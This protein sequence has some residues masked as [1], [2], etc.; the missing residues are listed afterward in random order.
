M[1]QPTQSKQRRTIGFACSEAGTAA[2]E[3]AIV[4]GVI[5]LAIVS[6]VFY[7]GKAISDTAGALTA[8]LDSSSAREVV[9][10]LPQPAIAIQEPI[11]FQLFTT[12]F[13][14]ASAFLALGLLWRNRR[15]GT[16]I[17]SE[18]RDDFDETEVRS[19]RVRIS[20]TLKSHRA[21]FSEWSLN[22]EHV[23]LTPTSLL[24]EDKRKQKAQVTPTTA[25]N[26]RTFHVFDKADAAVGTLTQQDLDIAGVHLARVPDRLVAIDSKTAVSTAIVFMQKNS[27][28]VLP[29]ISNGSIVGLVTRDVLMT[30]LH[31][32]LQ[33]ISEIDADYRQVLRRAVGLET[34]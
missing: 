4:L 29:V 31:C 33:L 5:V 17:Q 1:S 10:E 2:T 25:V 7:T 21:D 30:T 13:L 19:Q 8:G 12:V 11:A 32:T 28:E 20:S 9:A 26:P 27:L 14:C 6:V 24:P 22:L 23:M 3:Y 15:V 16:Q 18:E 34:A